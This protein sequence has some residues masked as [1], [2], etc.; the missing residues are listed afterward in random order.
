MSKM[1]KR[2]SLLLMIIGFVV[3]V[4]GIFW[5]YVKPAKADLTAK[6]TASAEAQDNVTRLQAELTKLTKEVKKPTLVP[7]ADE[8]RLAKAYPYSEDVPVL[9]LQLEDLAKQTKVDLDSAAPA[10]GTDY[11]GVTGTPFTI[12]VTGKYWNVQD[13]LYRVHNRV[14]VDGKG[15]LAVKG[16][17]L[18]VTKAD[19]APAGGDTGASGTAT[20]ASTQ[21]TANITIVAFSRTAAGTGAAAAPAAQTSTNT[22]GTTS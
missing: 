19:L 1:N 17:L 15:R 12:A 22:G 4:G 9:I 6:Q 2:D 20:T 10:A 21:V 14:S 7:I 11:A 5:F 18:A 8:L 3:V 16:R 13:F